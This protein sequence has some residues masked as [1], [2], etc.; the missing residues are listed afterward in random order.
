MKGAR[1]LHEAA[2]PRQARAGVKLIL[3]KCKSPIERRWRLSSHARSL[4]VAR[5]ASVA[6]PGQTPP[7]PNEAGDNVITQPD[8]P[9]SANRPVAIRPSGQCHL[10]D[11]NMLSEKS[12]EPSLIMA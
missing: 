9:P 5:V 12:V 4:G 2:S 10:L 6:D 11:D 7:G 1:E 8:I 3:C